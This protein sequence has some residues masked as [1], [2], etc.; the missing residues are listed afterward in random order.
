MRAAMWLLPK[1]A[2]IASNTSDRM[3]EMPT[4]IT[5]M[6]ISNSIIDMPRCFPLLSR[7]IEACLSV[8]I[9]SSLVTRSRLLV[10]DYS[11]H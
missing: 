7:W 2:A 6:A 8:I 5:V 3:P 11:F 10:P 9:I 1:V 4:A